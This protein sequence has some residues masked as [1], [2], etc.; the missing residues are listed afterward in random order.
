MVTRHADAK[1]KRQLNALAHSAYASRVV[2]KST[3]RRLRTH[4]VAVAELVP[5]VRCMK[6]AGALT[7]Q[8]ADLQRTRSSLDSS[9]WTMLTRT[10]TRLEAALRPF[11]GD[12]AP[13]PRQCLAHVRKMADYNFRPRRRAATAVTPGHT[14]RGSYRHSDSA[15][16]PVVRRQ[17]EQCSAVAS[18]VARDAVVR[19]RVAQGPPIISCSSASRVPVADGDGRSVVQ[20][21]TPVECTR[22]APSRS[23]ASAHEAEWSDASPVHGPCRL[24]CGV[25]TFRGRLLEDVW[26]AACL[27]GNRVSVPVTRATFNAFETSSDVRLLGV[28]ACC[29]PTVHRS[30]RALCSA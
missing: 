27:A 23:V 30:R 6:D 3:V 10:A 9:R 19:P 2:A 14:V 4:G 25:N 1:T 11:R 5:L 12:P 26:P 15:P 28:A 17:V 8:I 20:P 7:M 18:A 29:P 21:T 13:S 24:L 22:C 16:E